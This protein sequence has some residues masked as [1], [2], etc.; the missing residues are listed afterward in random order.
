PVALPMR[1]RAGPSRD[2][3]RAAARSSAAFR[4]EHIRRY[5]E[6]DRDSSSRGAPARRWHRRAGRSDSGSPT[7]YSAPGGG[8]LA[9]AR[10][11]LNDLGLAAHA[12]D[13]AVIDQ[14]DRMAGELAQ[15]DDLLQRQRGGPERDRP[16]T[17]HAIRMHFAYRMQL[18]VKA[19]FEQLTIIAEQRAITP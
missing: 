9:A 8:P 18:A 11:R 16:I 2:R 6:N 1:P 10:E 15:L 13:F 19:Q 12:G 4:Q 17:G 3:R 14:Q 7:A 5:V